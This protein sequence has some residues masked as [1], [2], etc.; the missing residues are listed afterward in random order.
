MIVGEMLLL[1][2]AELMKHFPSR[3]IHLACGRLTALHC[4]QPSF[5]HQGLLDMLTCM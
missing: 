3:F 2:E 5:S 4:I 1:E